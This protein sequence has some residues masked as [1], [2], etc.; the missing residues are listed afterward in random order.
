M[1]HGQS[2]TR[3]IQIENPNPVEMS[4]KQKDGECDGE[5]TVTDVDESA[6]KN[7]VSSAVSSRKRLLL[8]LFQDMDGIFD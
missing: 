2:V 1:G 3:K 4:S 8:K 6:F 5:V 7:T